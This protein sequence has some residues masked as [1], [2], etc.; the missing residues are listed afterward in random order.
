MRLLLHRQLGKAIG[1]ALVMALAII[2][3]IILS[4]LRVW[5]TNSIPTEQ[6]AVIKSL[7][8]IKGHWFNSL[9]ATAWATAFLALATFLLVL[10]TLYVSRRERSGDNVSPTSL[11]RHFAS[12]GLGRLSPGHSTLVNDVD[13]HVLEGVDSLPIPKDILDFTGHKELTESIHHHILSANDP[14]SKVT[15]LHGPPGVGKTTLAIHVAHLVTSDF[16]DG[17]VF[18]E[19]RDAYGQPRDPYIVLEELLIH[20]GVAAARIPHDRRLRSALYRSL[21]KDKRN[22]IVLDNAVSENQLQDLLPVDH[23][24]RVIITSRSTLGSLQACKRYMLQVLDASTSLELFTKIVGRQRI[25]QDHGSA[26]RIVKLC[27]GLPLSLRITGAKTAVRTHLDLAYMAEVLDEKTGKLDELAIGDLRSRS[28]VS[29]SYNDLND[30]ERML[31]RLL[32]IITVSTFPS[33]V[34]SALLG[35]SVNNGERIIQRLVDINLLAA[36]ERDQAR[37]IRYGFHDLVRELA[38]ERLH[39]EESSESRV[40]ALTRLASCYLQRSREAKENEEAKLATID[41]T[42]TNTLDNRVLVSARAALHWRAAERTSLVSLVELTAAAGMWQLSSDITY[43]VAPY[44]EENS[45]WRDL[46]VVYRRAMDA[47]LKLGDRK[48][49]KMVSHGLGVMLRDRG[50]FKESA[51]HLQAALVICHEINDLT[52][53][54]KLRG[55]I[56]VLYQYTGRFEM[57]VDE[58]DKSLRLFDEGDDEPGAGWALRSLGQVYRDLGKFELAKESLSRALAIFKRTSDQRGK[59]WVMRSF[60]EVYRLQE[61]YADSEFELVNAISILADAGDDRGRA[62]ALR[63]LGDLR[64]QQSMPIEAEESFEEGLRIFRRLGDRRGV[65]W[66]ARS[67]GDM[68]RIRGEYEQAT[69]SFGESRDFFHESGAREWEAIASRGL[70]ETFRDE[71]SLDQAITA[72]H[73]CI[74]I[75]HEVSDKRREGRALLELARIYDSMNMVD[76]AEQTRNKARLLSSDD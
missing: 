1:V 62:W 60:G 2:M 22:L 61:N 41:P 75:F 58:F 59:G 10:S 11:D 25:E 3:F 49:E 57:A 37:Q 13:I 18:V 51:E 16:V 26:E 68:H 73:D 71:G 29:W 4:A 6:T 24:S 14:L 23:S 69:S 34:A 76:T 56:A 28:I 46:E 8:W 12:P 74:K 55:D 66:T 40:L 47:A 17:Q 48:L 27:G 9:A 36:K 33:W 52:A 43:C 39:A 44:L 30:Q 38:I 7:Y 20:L 53:E 35:I 64:L 70:A 32:A 65:A 42:S 19:L 72:Y 5:P 15:L 54:A 21:L 45:H 50:D 63:A 31:F 67:L